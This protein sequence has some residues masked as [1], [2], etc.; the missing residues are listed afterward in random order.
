VLALHARALNGD[1]SAGAGELAAGM[2]RVVDRVTGDLVYEGPEAYAVPALLDAVCERMQRGRDH[3]AAAAAWLHAATMAILP[4]RQGNVSVAHLLATLALRRG[5]FDRVEFSV[6]EAWWGRRPD[7]HWAALACLGREFSFAAD[8]TPFVEVHLRAQLER[9]AS[10]DARE[11]TERQAWTAIENIVADAGFAA[12]VAEAVW[13]A[14]WGR[15]VTA[16]YYTRLVGVSPATATHDLSRATAAGLLLAR[17][18]RRGRRY[19]AGIA[20]YDKVANALQI[21]AGGSKEIER[22]VIVAELQRRQAA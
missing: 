13:D 21:R 20:L 1:W 6:H 10:V 5:G 4:F 3:P 18:E 9:A 19:G 2:R 17:G 7:E 12:R 22:A 11:R 8:V 16:G 14:F 15:E